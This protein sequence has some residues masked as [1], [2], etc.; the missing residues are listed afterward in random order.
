MQKCIDPFHMQD[1]GQSEDI[2]EVTAQGPVQHTKD[3]GSQKNMEDRLNVSLQKIECK[4]LYSSVLNLYLHV[5][6]LYL[7]SRRE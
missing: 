4:Y 2:D 5:I 1:P 3:P 6:L 7:F